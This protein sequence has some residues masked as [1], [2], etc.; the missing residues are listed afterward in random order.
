MFTN[1]RL[2]IKTFLQRRYFLLL[3]V[4]GVTVLATF[5]GYYIGSAVQKNKYTHFM[6]S[7]KTVRENSDKYALINPLIGGVSAP[8]TDVGMFND[9]KGDLISYLKQEERR[10]NLYGYSFYFRDFNTGMWFGTNENLEFFPASLFKL[11]LALAIY[12]QAESEEGF[13]KKNVIY[14]KELSDINTSIKSNS[15]S[16]LEIGGV[17]SIEEL[18]AIMLTKSD[19]GAKNLLLASSNS[20]Y[21]NGLFAIVSMVSPDTQKV[22]EVSSREYALFFRVLYGSSYLNE[23]NSEYILKL[24]SESSFKNGLVAGV[25]E[26]IPV[27]HKYGTYEFME[28]VNGKARI[29][30]QLHDCGVIYSSKDPYILCVMTKGKDET[31]L[32]R[33]VS[34]VSNLM[35][36][37]QNNKSEDE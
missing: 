6:K 33:I 16:I 27:A 34:H 36:T 31:N 17:Y 2:T 23:E 26:G 29:S 14:T 37:Y 11:P 30:R 7:F 1:T 28:D 3:L 13:L 5:L 8:A 10:G 15:Q 24:L 21:L 12:K 32:F 22:L 4:G 25:P 9:I 35:Y 19:N 20:S 18:V